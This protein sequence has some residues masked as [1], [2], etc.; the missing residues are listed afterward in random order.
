[1]LV[2]LSKW[3]NSLGLRIPQSIVKHIG[4]SAQEPLELFIEDNHIVI[5]KVYRLDTLL[6]QIT[7]ENIHSEI[8]TGP[9][10]GS[11]AW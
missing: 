4:L 10:Q 5:Q 2:T 7:P 1:M 3:G 6:A 8:D 9:S 11:E